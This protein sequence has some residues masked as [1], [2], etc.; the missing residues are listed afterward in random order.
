MY[1]IGPRSEVGGRTGAKS[2]EVFSRFR[3]SILQAQVG[4]RRLE[5]Q[6][7]GKFFPGGRVEGRGGQKGK[8]LLSFRNAQN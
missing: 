2:G 7:Q 8:F 1:R 4:W 3:L 5:G 6:S